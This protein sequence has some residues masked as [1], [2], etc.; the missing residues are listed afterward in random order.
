MAPERKRD[1]NRKRDALNLS[2]RGSP[3]RCD[4]AS[5][6]VMCSVAHAS[7]STKSPG[8]SCAMGVVHAS[9]VDVSGRPGTV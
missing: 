4:R 7:A 6:R 8:M 9:G 5:S 3:V 2:C 1:R